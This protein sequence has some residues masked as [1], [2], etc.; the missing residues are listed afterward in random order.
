MPASAPAPRWR[1]STAIAGTG[2]GQDRQRVEYDNPADYYNTAL[3]MA[4][5]RAH[6]DAILTAT[7]A[8]DCFTQDVEDMQR[9]KR[10]RGV[11]PRREGKSP[12]RPHPEIVVEE[13]LD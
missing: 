5:K 10:G 8:S 2:Y 3:K 12:R 13:N 9:E 4:K 6:V 1:R 7:A 11:P